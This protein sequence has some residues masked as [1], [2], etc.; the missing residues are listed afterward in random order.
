[1][2]ISRGTFRTP[3]AP[4]AAYRNKIET[5]LTE[6]VKTHRALLWTTGLVASC[7][8]GGCAIE[9]A[10]EKQKDSPTTIEFQSSPL[11]GFDV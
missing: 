10:K 2:G 6:T 1:M 7:L 4:I 9:Q 5:V 11:N 3:L 8:I